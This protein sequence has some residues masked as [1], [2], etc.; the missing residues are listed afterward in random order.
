MKIN[1][2][3]LKLEQSYLFTNIGRKVSAYQA[4]HPD[5]KN[6]PAGNR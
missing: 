4:E 1:E 6:H 3:Y 2:N 5:Q